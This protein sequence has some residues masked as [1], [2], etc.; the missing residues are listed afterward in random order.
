MNMTTFIVSGKQ[1]IEFHILVPR[2]VYIF[3]RS[4]RLAL[5]SPDGLRGAMALGERNNGL[6]P[7]SHDSDIE[8]CE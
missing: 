8:I 4:G 3:I 7:K 5:A 6:L 2:W 1:L